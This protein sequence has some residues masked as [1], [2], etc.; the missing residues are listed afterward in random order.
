MKI[1]QEKKNP[2]LDKV[3]TESFIPLKEGEP[4]LGFCCHSLIK[5][6]LHHIRRILQY[7]T[8]SH[9]NRTGWLLEFL[10]LTF[11]LISGKLIW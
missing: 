11:F 8:W 3:H 9:G 10:V 7:Q 6:P 1:I 5:Y 4:C 2:Y